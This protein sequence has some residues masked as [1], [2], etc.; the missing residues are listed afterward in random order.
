MNL[1]LR[2]IERLK[3]FFKQIPFLNLLPRAVLNTLHLSLRKRQYQ[4]GHYVCQEGK[5]SGEIF[6]VLRGEFEVSKVVDTATAESTIASNSQ[7]Q[8]RR[9][10]ASTGK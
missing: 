6:I 7:A 4:H 2:R 10:V 9:K 3:E 8:K 5:D 1:E